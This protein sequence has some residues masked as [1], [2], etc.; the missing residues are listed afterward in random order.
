MHGDAPE[1]AEIENIPAIFRHIERYLGQVN[2]YWTQTL[3]G[4]ACLFQVVRCTGRVIDTT[5][6]CTVGLGNH[7]FRDKDDPAAAPLRHE[8][9][10]AVPTSFGTRNIP[11][12][13]QQ[14]G[15]IA[16]NRDR[17]FTRGEVM[18]GTNPVFTDWPFRGFY[19]SHPCVIDDD[20]FAEFSREDGENVGFLW[21]APLYPGEID[22]VRKHGADRLET[23]FAERNADLVDLNRRPVA[24]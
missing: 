12:L 18:M 20:A 5:F 19:A 14:L 10:I 21:M 17:P 22:L 2:G 9:L 16:V 15:L 7:A 4:D 1:D 11:P 13:L 6:F 3:E 23:L 8:L 24:E